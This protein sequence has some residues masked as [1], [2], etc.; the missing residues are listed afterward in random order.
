V[1]KSC[2]EAEHLRAGGPRGMGKMSELPRVR[3]AI[4]EREEAASAVWIEKPPVLGISISF[5]AHCGFAEAK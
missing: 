1:S 3:T 4:P 5:S 2:P